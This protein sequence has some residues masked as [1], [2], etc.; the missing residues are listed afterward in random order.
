M[1]STTPTANVC[2]F[3]TLAHTWGTLTHELTSAARRPTIRISGFPH[4]L[5]A[6]GF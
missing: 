4:A 2:G 1:F 3:L 6:L 5:R